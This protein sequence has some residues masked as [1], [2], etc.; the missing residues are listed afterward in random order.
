MIGRSVKNFFIFYL[1]D[2]IQ[3]IACYLSWYMIFPQKEEPT[4]SVQF[5]LI[6]FS[7]CLR[8]PFSDPCSIFAL[9]LCFLRSPKIVLSFNLSQFM[10]FFFTNTV[11]KIFIPFDF[12]LVRIE[13][14][15]I[16][17]LITFHTTRTKSRI[18]IHVE[19]WKKSPIDWM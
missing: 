4:I 17:I 1:E 16:R 8:E 3:L 13:T 10:R 6:S 5:L 18:G 15:K 19:Y 9:C 12:C 2:Q 7:I 14:I 11:F